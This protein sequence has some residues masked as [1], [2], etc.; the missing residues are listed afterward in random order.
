MMVLKRYLTIVAIVVS[1]IMFT[2]CGGGSSSSDKKEGPV[3]VTQQDLQTSTYIYKGN[4]VEVASHAYKR[5]MDES[6]TQSDMEVFLPGD[7]ASE[8][9]TPSL[10]NIRAISTENGLQKI[11]VQNHLNTLEVKIVD[12][13]NVNIL[14][15][16]QS[17]TVDRKMPL[18]DLV[19]VLSEEG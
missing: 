4:F 1:M 5:V 15:K 7:D 17:F 16:S 2:A 6:F 11:I 3:A 9:I 14:L 18:D 19:A 10:Y 12:K 13:E 8:R